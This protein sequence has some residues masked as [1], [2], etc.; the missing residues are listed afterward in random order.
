MFTDSPE[1][2]SVLQ[3]KYIIEWFVAACVLAL[4][5]NLVFYISVVFSTNTEL[6]SRVFIILSVFALLSLSIGVYRYLHISDYVEEERQN[7]KAQVNQKVVLLS[8]DATFNVEDFGVVLHYK[9]LLSDTHLKEFESICKNYAD[10]VFDIAIID[11]FSSV[12]NKIIISKNSTLAENLLLNRDYELLNTIAPYIK[13]P[14][15]RN[16]DYIGKVILDTSLFESIVNDYLLYDYVDVGETIKILLQNGAQSTFVDVK[17]QNLVTRLMMKRDFL[18]KT[19]NS[20]DV[21]ADKD[22]Y[23]KKIEEINETIQILGGEPQ[24]LQ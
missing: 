19:F 21:Q 24:E 5:A 17:G 9:H 22:R 8:N 1:A 2:G 18:Q 20:S 14:N 6:R 16:P 11:P 15:Y 10:T 7:I 3:N 4:L 13:N 23:Y 12:K